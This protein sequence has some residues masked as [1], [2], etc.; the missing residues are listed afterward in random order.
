MLA[1]KQ[2]PIGSG[3]RTAIGCDR[4]SA[5]ALDGMHSL[6]CLHLLGGYDCPPLEPAWVT[7]DLLGLPQGA[8]VALGP[9]AGFFLRL[10]APLGGTDAW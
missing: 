5:A 10:A 2:G 8:Q 6:E 7:A 3:V 9:P 4:V 1:P